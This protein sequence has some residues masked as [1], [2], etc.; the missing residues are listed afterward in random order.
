MYTNYAKF[1]NYVAG[2]Y[3]PE[4]DALYPLWKAGTPLS[5][6]TVFLAVAE[7]L[8][9]IP[10]SFRGDSVDREL[11]KSILTEWGYTEPIIGGAVNEYRGSTA[12]DPSQSMDYLIP[13]S[14]L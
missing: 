11:V 12:D 4:K 13:N 8:E 2:F 3:C 10:Y 5:L 6:E 9:D 7:Y 1:I 14:W